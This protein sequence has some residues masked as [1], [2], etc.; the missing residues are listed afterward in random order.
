MFFVRG[1]RDFKNVCFF[2]I[3][4]VQIFETCLLFM[5]NI[6]NILSEIKI[7]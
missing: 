6:I 7:R 5:V 2:L 3:M 1:Y 4:I